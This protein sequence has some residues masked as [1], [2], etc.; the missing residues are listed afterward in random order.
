[1]AILAKM[2]V[3]RG[4]DDP[5]ETSGRTRRIKSK[6]ISLLKYINALHQNVAYKT[7]LFIDLLLT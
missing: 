6:L 5:V 3:N 2:D 7:F 4:E 1:L